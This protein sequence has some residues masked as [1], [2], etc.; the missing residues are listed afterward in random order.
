MGRPTFGGGGSGISPAA[1]RRQRLAGRPSTNAP[2]VDGVSKSAGW[3]EHASWWEATFTDGADAEYERQIIPALRGALEGCRRVL[4]LGCGEGQVARSLA[5][6]AGCL[7]GI[8]PSWEQVRRA[9]E[10]GGG[11]GFLSGDGVDLP[12]PDEA[13]DGLAVCLVLEHIDDLDGVLEE[14]ARVLEPGGRLAIVLNH[15]LLQPPGS[16][17]VHDHMIDPP[18]TYWRVGPYLS[19]RVFEEEI[20]PGHHVRFVHRPLGRYINALTAAGLRL[21]AVDE[22]RPLDDV[23]LGGPPS[24]MLAEV[25]RMLVVAAVR[26]PKEADPTPG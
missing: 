2:T 24:E 11:P 22:P 9:A 25:P 26:A 6:V 13:F 8:D 3:D 12:F 19:E 5:D 23:A 21:V 17:W 7:V 18:E 20:E 4:D 14:M 1:D 10:K 16:G 15:P